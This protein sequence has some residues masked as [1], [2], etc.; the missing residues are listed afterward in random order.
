MTFILT[1]QTASGEQVVDLDQPNLTIGTLPS[2][3]IVLSGQRIEPIHGLI[4]LLDSGRWRVTDL[5]SDSGISVNGAKIGVEK[6][7]VAGDSISIGTVKLTFDFRKLTPPPIPAV[8][9]PVPPPPQFAAMADTAGLETTVSPQPIEKD[10]SAPVERGQKLFSP[11]NA[12]PAGDVLEVVAYWDDTVLEVELYEAQKGD[13]SKVRIGRPPEDDFLAAG[14]KG[15]KN[16]A[17]AKATE[18]GYKIKLIEGMKGRLRKSGSVEKV[19]E[20]NYSLSRRDIAHIKYGPISYFMLYVRPPVLSLPK[21]SPRDPLFLAMF[22]AGLILFL[23]IA[24]GVLTGTPSNL[25]ESKKDELWEVITVPKESKPIELAKKEK[26]KPVEVK[27]TP[28]PKPKVPPPK[29]KVPTPKP[30]VKMVEKKVKPKKVYKQKNK[31][32]TETNKITGT[33]KQPPKPAKTAGMAKKSNK[34]D[35]KQSGQKI[36]GVKT[37]PSGGPRGGGNSKAGAP[38]KG[39]SN[40]SVMGVEGVKNNK[41][42]GVNLSK[43]GL[44]AGKV[45]NKSGPGAIQTNFKSSAGG[46]G[47]GMGS[48]KR[49]LGLGGGL[50][51][52]TSLG[53]GGSSAGI[54]NFGSGSGGLLSGAGGSGGLGGFGGGRGTGDGGRR[55]VAVSVGT[56]G[57]PGVSGGLTTEEVMQVIRANLNQIRY[58]YEQV[59]QRSPNKSGKIKVNFVVAANGRVT[60]ARIASDTVG[61]ARMGACVTGKIKMWKFP[62]PRGGQKVDINYPFVFN[63]S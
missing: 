36:A 59:L 34:P 28:P 33:R 10:K 14:P 61:D 63:P 27:K 52:G 45:L 3:Q 7:L 15:L 42:S 12:K 40:A 21:S 11:R 50:G 23:A 19:S 30:K 8:G 44:G 47:G 53:L 35:F 25:D 1:Y 38:R 16:Y 55:P 43:L 51:K 24:F 29:P 48:G 26:K 46:A 4:E 41:A 58:C 39:K 62:R 31:E 60:T 22:N 54:N 32:N 20:G 6:E 13:A 9:A 56:G 2:N 49:T 17:L 37:G 5:G 18:G 57:A